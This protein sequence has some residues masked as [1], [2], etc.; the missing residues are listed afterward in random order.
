MQNGCSNKYLSS[1]PHL[2]NLMCKKV[3]KARMW[4][5]NKHMLVRD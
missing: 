3:E 1:S 2:E 5:D 4:E